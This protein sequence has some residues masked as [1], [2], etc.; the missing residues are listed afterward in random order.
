MLGGPL[1]FKDNFSA[2]SAIS[3]SQKDRQEALGSACL[4]CNPN[5]SSGVAVKP[6]WEAPRK[7]TL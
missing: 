3:D 4:C 1:N 2:K 7:E 5:P 6:A